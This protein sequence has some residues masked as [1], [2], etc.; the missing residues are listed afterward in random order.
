MFTIRMTRRG[1]LRKTCVVTASLIVGSFLLLGGNAFA[2]QKAGDPDAPKVT[3]WT[4]PSIGAFTGSGAWI[5]VDLRFALDRAVRDINSQGG[6]RGLP[7]VIENYD[8]GGFNPD[9]AVQMFA[10]AEPGALVIVGPIGSSEN[11]ACGTIAAKA[12]IL[13][14]GSGS[15]DWS[16]IVDCAPWMFTPYAS[17]YDDTAE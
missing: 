2:A 8:T 16:V 1:L 11:V 9:K 17:C 4:L 7:V 5:G 3:S 6:I 10:K 12:G 13:Y 15:S 14:L